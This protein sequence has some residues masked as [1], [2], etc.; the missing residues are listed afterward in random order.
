MPNPDGTPTPE[1]L[2]QA[3]LRQIALSSGQGSL[4]TTNAGLMG[5]QIVDPKHPPKGAWMTGT[6]GNDQTDLGVQNELFGNLSD[7]EALAKQQGDFELGSH[8]SAATTAMLGNAQATGDKYSAIFGGDAARA[9]DL[10]AAAGSRGLGVFQGNTSR[11]NAGV[12]NALQDR[13]MQTGSYGALMNFANQGPGD[14][15]AQAQLRDSTNANTANA[16]AMARSGRGMGGSAA[17]MRQAIAQNAVAQQTSNNQMAALRAQENTAYQAQRL[18][19]LGQA[20][21]IAGQTVSADQGTAATGLA[22]AQYQTNTALQGTQ[23]NDASSQAWA[24]QQQAAQQQG[25][26]A[27]MGAQTQQ[28]NINATALAGRESQW[29]SA[30]QT[31]GI[32]TGNATQAGIADANRQQAYIGAG[33]SAAGS[34]IAATS[35]ERAKTNITPLG[36]PTGQ[37]QPL[38]SQAPA[39][40]APAPS[41]PSKQ[42]QEQAARTQTAGTVGQVGG[43]AVGTAIGG[44]VGGIVGSIAGKQLG[45]MFSDVRSKTDVTPL[46]ALGSGLSA[47]GKYLQSDRRDPF[48]ELDS[49]SKKYGAGGVASDPKAVKDYSKVPTA[50]FDDVAGTD[51]TEKTNDK[52]YARFARDESHPILSKG[53]ALLADSARNAPGS[54][55]RYKDPRDGA[56]TYVGPMAQDLAAHPVTQ[57]TVGEDPQTGKLYVDGM[58]LATVN[59]AQNHAQQNQLDAHQTE[60]DELRSMLDESRRRELESARGGDSMGNRF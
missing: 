3:K 59:T 45:K 27:E 38:P 22:G 12:T 43:A 40:S 37:V 1:E 14:S 21:G 9:G 52:A 18:N 26:G 19:A 36:T 23:L 7:A 44:P 24:Q 42:Q 55:Y 25:M 35:D 28:L 58:R 17:A 2:K 53:D 32:D 48:A 60:L 47:G 54:M 6:Y 11:Y 50:R 57:S 29:A 20:G 56:G 5:R 30:N 8:N 41:G 34:V 13:S 15:A 4:D 31:H 39:Q 46:S 10:S 16:L 49:L 51:T 33:A